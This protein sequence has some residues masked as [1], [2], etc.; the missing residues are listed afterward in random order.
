MKIC[1]LKTHVIERGIMTQLHATSDFTAVLTLYMSDR[2]IPSFRA[3]SKASGLSRSAI[4]RLRRG[5]LP[6][7]QVNTLLKLASFLKID[8]ES[9]VRS[10]S[11]LPIDPEEQPLNPDESYSVPI[12]ASI[13]I[14][15]STPI[16]RADAE[17]L[18]QR[19]ALQTL[20]PLLLQWSAAATAAQNNPQLP[21][22]RLLPLLRPME[23]LLTEWGVTVIGSVGED[24]AYDPIEHQGM[25]SDDML[26]PGDRVRVRFSGYRHLGNLLHRAKVSRSVQ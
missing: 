2:G 24:L 10:L 14:P 17:E 23:L 12:S 4:D 21:A 13:S 22:A 15:I 20:E 8:L 1:I 5:Q 25:E 6:Q 18:F 16:S 11:P 19:S 7:M 26:H 3:L 9:L